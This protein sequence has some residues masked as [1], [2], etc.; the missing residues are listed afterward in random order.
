MNGSR[1]LPLLLSVDPRSRRLP[2]L[3]HVD[4]GSRRRPR[5]FHV[6]NHLAGSLN[7][8]LSVRKYPTMGSLV[9]IDGARPRL[10]HVENHLASGLN[11]LLSIRKYPTAGSLVSI[12]G[13]NNGGHL[14]GYLVSPKQVSYER[15]DPPL[16]V[17][18]VPTPP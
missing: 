7:R 1:R 15:L 4:N 13:A 6:K 14:S 10:F 11:R 9:S 3:L 18:S 12:D 16:A 8:L 5:L 2:R 17:D